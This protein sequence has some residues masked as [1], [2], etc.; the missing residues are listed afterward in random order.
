ME[1]VIVP[2]DGA[3]EPTRQKH[4]AFKARRDPRA[5]KPCGLHHVLAEPDQ[6]GFADEIAEDILN[7]PVVDGETRPRI[8][9]PSSLPPGEYRQILQ[10][11]AGRVLPHA[12]WAPRAA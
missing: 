1:R 6:V 10:D 9:L 12:G 7:D 3:E 11:I 8:A 4:R 5:R 2:L